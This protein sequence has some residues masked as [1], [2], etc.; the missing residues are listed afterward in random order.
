M[1]DTEEPYCRSSQVKLSSLCAAG[2]TPS[3]R[4]S[5]WARTRLVLLPL[6]LPLLHSYTRPLLYNVLSHHATSTAITQFFLLLRPAARALSCY[7]TGPRLGPP[8]GVAR[9]APFA[10]WAVGVTSNL[11][12][13]RR[14]KAKAAKPA[15]ALQAI[16]PF[17]RLKSAIEAAMNILFNELL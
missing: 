8:Q 4:A 17:P 14:C 13:S 16:A 11:R 7:C 12:G 5:T 2:L 9:F 1:S 15:R 6:P 3:I 10:L